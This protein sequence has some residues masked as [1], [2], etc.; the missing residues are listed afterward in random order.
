[1]FSNI[2]RLISKESYVTE[3]VYLEFNL[4]KIKQ[5]LEEIHIN[6]IKYQ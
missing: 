2:F 4:L 5:N 3:K 1:M 6:K